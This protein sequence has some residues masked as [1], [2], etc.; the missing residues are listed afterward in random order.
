MTKAVQASNI[1]QINDS[2]TLEID[3][4]HNSEVYNHLNDEYDIIRYQL[5]SNSELTNDNDDIEYEKIY[6]NLYHVTSK[7]M[8]KKN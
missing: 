1:T 7:V 4:D 3:Y 8:A 5:G 6:Q 2:T